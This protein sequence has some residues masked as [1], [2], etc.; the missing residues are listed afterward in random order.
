MRLLGGRP[1]PQTTLMVVGDAGQPQPMGT[2]GRLCFQGGALHLGYGSQLNGEKSPR[3]QLGD[4]EGS[5]V[6]NTGV[7]AVMYGDKT[8]NV[9]NVNINWYGMQ[10]RAQERPAAGAAP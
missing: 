3:G 5:K 10:E 7:R 6:H 2:P 8:V 1:A 4:T 9:T